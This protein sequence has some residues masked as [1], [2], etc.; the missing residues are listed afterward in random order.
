MNKQILF[1]ELLTF[2]K[3]HENFYVRQKKSAEAIEELCLGIAQ[4]TKIKPNVSANNPLSLREMTCLILL[5]IGMNP[6]RCADLLNISI[7]SLSTYE[8]RI[9]KKLGARN[10]THAFYLAFSN[11][12]LLLIKK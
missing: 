10:R 3:Q 9:R 4:I 8:D 2:F 5:A 11:E 6:A 12:Y 1:E 7:H